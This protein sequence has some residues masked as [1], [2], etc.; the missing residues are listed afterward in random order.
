[1]EDYQQLCVWPGCV[2]GKDKIEEFEKFMLDDFDVRVKY[3]D[4]IKT[5]PDMKNGKPVKNT[6][7]RN[8]LFFYVHKDDVG[9]FSVPRL[10]AG[11]RWWEDI[12]FNRHENL[13]PKQFVIDHPRTW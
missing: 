6:G 12:F 8:D 13:Y 5:N 3:H 2:V 1:M 7:N 11:I 4:E 9:K 10:K